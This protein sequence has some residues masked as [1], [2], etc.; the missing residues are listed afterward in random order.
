MNLLFFWFPKQKGNTAWEGGLRSP[1]FAVWGDKFNQHHES[2]QA[3]QPR[4]YK[5]LTHISDFFPTILSIDQSSNYSEP[6]PRIPVDGYD[7][8]SIFLQS[9]YPKNN[10]TSPRTDV[11]AMLDI[12]L[13]MIAYRKYSISYYLI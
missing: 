12:Y 11:F 5:G 4:S 9:G 7:F 1:A 2:N 3:I 6:V 10:E 13:D 8:S